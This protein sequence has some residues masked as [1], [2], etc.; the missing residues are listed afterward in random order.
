MLF[1]IYQGKGYGLC[2]AIPGVVDKKEIPAVETT[3]ETETVV[4]LTEEQY[5]NALLMLPHSAA[6]DVL[7][8]SHALPVIFL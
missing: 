2:Y 5:K 3:E 7:P 4:T 6:T 8:I 1:C